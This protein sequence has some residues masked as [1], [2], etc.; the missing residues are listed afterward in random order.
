[1]FREIYKRI[2]R[3]L[4]ARRK[5]NRTRRWMRDRANSRL[6]VSL[7]SNSMIRRRV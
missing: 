6:I 7:Y 5:W 1:M 2:Q 4:V 3:H